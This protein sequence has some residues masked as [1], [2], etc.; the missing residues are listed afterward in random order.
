MILSVELFIAFRYLRSKRKEVFVS[1]IAVVSILSVAISVMV[2]D[3]VLSVMTG[4]ENELRAKLIGANAHVVIRKF[5]GNVEQWKEV[6]DLVVRQNGIKGVFPYTYNQ[7]M[8]TVS[9][10]ARGLIIKG[11]AD[12][13][14][15]KEKLEQYLEAGTTMSSLFSPAE[16]EILRPDGQKDLIKLSP[17][18]IGRELARSMGLE[19]GSIVSLFAPTLMSSPQGLIPKQRRFVVVGT[20]SSGLVEYESGM[21][22]TSLEA[23][24]SFFKFEKGVTGLEV[25]VKNIFEA[26]AIADNL[27]NALQALDDGYYATDWTEPN[28][29]LWE[30]IRLEKRVYFI[31]LLLLILVASFSIVSTLVMV[32]MEKGKDIAVFKSMGASA[33]SI[34]KIFFIQG[35][36]IGTS[37]TFLGTILGVFGCLALRSY[38][39]E[40]DRSVFSLDT[41]PVEMQPINFIIVAISSLIITSLAGVY[42]ARRAAKLDPV[43]ALRYE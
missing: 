5:G 1:I 10:G 41:V 8:L 35:A 34:M 31:V 25:V 23:A 19:N 9:G 2:L 28:K 27:A 36:L 17:L 7:A 13:P 26:T 4:F 40:I 21:A 30:A 39:F 15:A 43:E 33:D 3:I 37:G 22:Y 16:V 6:S 32:V 12:E 20:Y 24:Q 11:I 18:I 38:G 42:P 29:P 14:L